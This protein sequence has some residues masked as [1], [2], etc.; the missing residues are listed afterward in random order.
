MAH[1]VI[2]CGDARRM[3]ALSDGSVQ[4]VVTSPPY[5]V[6][7]AYATHSDDL[8]PTSEC[9]YAQVFCCGSITPI[10]W[11]TLISKHDR[12]SCINGVIR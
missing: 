9:G 4:L 7:K 12:K 5:N 2:I 11:L 8:P 6:G 10:E 3:D 1:D